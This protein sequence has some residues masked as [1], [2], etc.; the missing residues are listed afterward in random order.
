M[1]SL[2]AASFI[3]FDQIFARPAS[4]LC[5]MQCHHIEAK[6]AY[7]TSFRGRGMLLCSSLCLF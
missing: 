5:I 1:S 7:E 3:F 6:S 2:H 4:Y